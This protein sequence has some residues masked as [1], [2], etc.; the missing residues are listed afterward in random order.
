M[1]AATGLVLKFG[2]VQV[3]D[4]PALIA[5]PGTLTA[6]TGAS[7]SG[8]SSLLYLLSGLLVPSAGS[9]RWGS[10]DLAALG[11]SGRDA[12][13]RAT[14][15]FVFQNFHLV[16]EMSPIDNVL[17]PAWFSAIGGG[18]WRKRAADLLDRLGVPA[19][20]SVSL[21]SRGEQQRVAIARALLFDPPVVLAD[22]PTASLD[23]NS[24]AQVAHILRALAADDGKTVIVATHDPALRARATAVVTLDHGRRAA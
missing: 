22:E 13:R 18:G 7:G 9:V 24:G 19:R 14:A 6:L 5:E 17:L 16:E 23:A 2:A 4:V 11:E 21:L 1:L 15:G 3:V 12:W 10:I 20:G 8:K